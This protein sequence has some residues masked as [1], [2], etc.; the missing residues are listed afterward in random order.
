MLWLACISNQSQSS[1]VAQSPGCSDIVPAKQY[2]G[3]GLVSVEHFHVERRAVALKCPRKSIFRTQRTS[4]EVVLLF[5]IVNG[6]TQKGRRVLPEI[7]S[8]WQA[9]TCRLHPVS[10]TRSRQS[11]W[12][13]YHGSHTSCFTLLPA[14]FFHTGRR[15]QYV[16]SCLSFVWWNVHLQQ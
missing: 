16:V 8:Q 7:C 14:V 6:N 12:F 9:Y 3:G 2:W 1:W 11:I 10:Q 13:S 15:R 5:P 4:L